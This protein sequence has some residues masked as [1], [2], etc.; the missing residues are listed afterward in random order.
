MVAWVPHQVPGV[1]LPIHWVLHVTIN[2]AVEPPRHHGWGHIDHGNVSHLHT[3]TS[4]AM[5]APLV[6][7]DCSMSDSK[8]THIYVSWWG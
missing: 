6:G 8:A 7:Y 2:I 3:P 4:N 5:W 1:P